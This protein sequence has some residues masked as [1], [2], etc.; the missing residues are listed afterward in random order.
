MRE[1]DA[2]LERERRGGLWNSSLGELGGE[3]GQRNE[4]EAGRRQGQKVFMKGEIAHGNVNWK[5]PQRRGKLTEREG[6]NDGLR[7]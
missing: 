2:W 7:T 4:T 3:G 5:Y 1:I 6:R